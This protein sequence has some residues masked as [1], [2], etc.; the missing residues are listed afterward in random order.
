MRDVCRGQL[1]LVEAVDAALDLRARRLPAARL[2]PERDQW[3]RLNSAGLHHALHLTGWTV[4]TVGRRFL[5][6][7]G[8]GAPRNLKLSWLDGLLAA[9]PGRRGL[10]T[11]AFIAHPRP[12]HDRDSG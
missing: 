5:V 12:P 1:V 2:N 4:E 10:L 11:R 7:P 9:A 3:W 8:P 6:P